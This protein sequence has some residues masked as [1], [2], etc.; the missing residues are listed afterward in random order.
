MFYN[1]CLVFHLRG[2]YFRVTL[3][4]AS[5]LH[6]YIHQL[7][8]II[9]YIFLYIY[10]ILFVSVLSY[11]LVFTCGMCFCLYM[12]FWHWLWICEYL[13]TKRYT[14]SC[15]ER[16]IRVHTAAASV[17]TDLGEMYRQADTGAVVSLLARLGKISPSLSH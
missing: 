4:W 7:D 17:V 9:R 11:N 1:H 13:T 12:C 14:A 5:S 6:I 16:R 15:G 2:L 10:F 3:I 8:F